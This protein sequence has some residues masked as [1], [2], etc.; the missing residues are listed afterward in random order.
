M[1]CNRYEFIGESLRE[2]TLGIV[3][4]GRNGKLIS[5]YAKAFKMKVIYNDINK[6]KK[7]FCKSKAAI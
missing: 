7:K 2:K 4:M 1:R 5:Q 3:G 6:K